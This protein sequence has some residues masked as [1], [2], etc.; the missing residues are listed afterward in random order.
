MF[1]K[2]SKINIFLL[3]ILFSLQV[4]SSVQQGSSTSNLN[5]I[6]FDLADLTVD[7]DSNEGTIHL[8]AFKSTFNDLIIRG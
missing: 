6:V 2:I 7:Y 5:N 8:E 4:G 1:S 3:S